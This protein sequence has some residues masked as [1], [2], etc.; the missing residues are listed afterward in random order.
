[1][2]FHFASAITRKN[3][4]ELNGFDERYALGFNYDDTEFLQR[5]KNKNLKIDFVAD[6]YVIH[7][8]HGKM[9][10]NPSNPKATVNT[11]ELFEDLIK[12][13]FVRANNKDPIQ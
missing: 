3:L 1:V 11:K 9:F 12:T 2:A 13:P 7:Q 5:I 10:N 6:P 8:Y 4:I